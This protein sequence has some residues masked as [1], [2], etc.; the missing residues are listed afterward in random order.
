MLVAL[1]DVITEEW[2]M[3][4]VLKM[5]LS[6]SVCMNFPRLGSQSVI[7]AFIYPIA[8]NTLD[9]FDYLLWVD[10]ALLT[11][12]SPWQE[13]IERFLTALVVTS[14]TWGQPP[15]DP[16][17]NQGTGAF[18]RVSPWNDVKS[19]SN[20][21]VQTGVAVSVFRRVQFSGW[22]SRKFHHVVGTV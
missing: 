4:N 21:P 20:V 10:P 17:H 1:W 6:Q 15:S 9:A 16:L 18:T 12:V 14:C 8:T 5:E 2:S 19:Y 7:V 22:R 13:L 3:L 11:R